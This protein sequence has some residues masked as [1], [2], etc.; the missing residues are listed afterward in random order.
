MTDALW[1]L[2]GKICHVYLNDIIIWSQTVEKHEQ[3]CTTV[4]EALKKASMY[5]NQA[6]SNLFTAELCFLSHISGACIKPDPCKT[7][8]I[9][10]WPQPTTA[11]SVWGF[12]GLTR[13]IA[14]FLPA[15]TEYTSVLTLL[16]TKECDHEFLL[17]TAEHH[18][19]F[20]HIKD[21]VLGA[22]CLTIINY[23]DLVAVGQFWQ[24]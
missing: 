22:D 7:D 20:E 24:L 10:S 1:E 9:A 16:T 13:Y 19:A 11:T 5:C 8:C 21:L 12:L 4:L 2:I 18:A 14:T 17:W 3:N 15:L 6:K 23:E